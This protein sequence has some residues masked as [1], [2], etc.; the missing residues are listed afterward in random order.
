M[1]PVPKLI[2]KQ[3]KNKLKLNINH[4]DVKLMTN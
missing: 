4:S 1:F 3:N 2:S